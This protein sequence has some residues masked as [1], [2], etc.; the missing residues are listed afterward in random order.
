LDRTYVFATF[1]MAN[2]TTYIYIYID[3]A[4][5]LPRIKISSSP[6]DLYE[7]YD[8]R[9]KVASLLRMSLNVLFP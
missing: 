5:P 2:N 4:L 6:F 7:R 8:L 1:L 3:I 9:V